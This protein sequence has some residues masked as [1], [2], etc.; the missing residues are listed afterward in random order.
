MTLSSMVVSRDWQEISVLECILSSLRM[1]V[2]VQPEPKAAQAK[3]EKSKVDAIIIDYDLS[4]TRGFVAR[5]RELSE[6]QKSTPLVIVSG[7]RAEGGLEEAH[8]N[9]VFEKPISVEQA[10]RTLSAARNIILDGRLRYHRQPLDIPV[11]LKF[12]RRKLVKAFLR[13]VSQGGVG[14]RLVEDLRPQGPVRVGFELPGMRRKVAA[15]GVF[16]WENGR[17]IAGIRFREVDGNARRH[18]Q[19]WLEQR[20]FAQEWA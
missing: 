13:N 4:G 6:R 15:T 19:L 8:A 3:L 16:A 9:F 5:L 12:P 18:L 2:D 11:S 10:V 7:S 17:G 14:V 20:Y 1:H